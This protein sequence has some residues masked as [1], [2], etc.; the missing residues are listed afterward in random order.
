MLACLN[1]ILLG[2]KSIGIVAHRVQH[3]EAFQSLVACI[4]I[5]GDVSQ[6]MTHMQT[7]TAGVG[8]HV[9]Y[10]EFLLGFVFRD[11]IGLL[12]NPAPLPL[13]LNLSEIIVHT[14]FRK[15]YG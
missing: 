2:R 8:E 11:A 9:E 13:L 14:F 7:G 10:V 6:R 3:V 5:A 12:F 15:F 4:D 1:G